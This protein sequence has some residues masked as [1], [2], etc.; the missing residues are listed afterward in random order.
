MGTTKVM[1]LL[2]NDTKKGTEAVEKEKT[3]VEE[4]STEAADEVGEDTV[5]GPVSEETVE[6]EPE[7][8]R[9]K[10]PKGACSICEVVKKRGMVKGICTACRKKA[11]KEKSIEEKEV[12]EEAEEAVEAEEQDE[13]PAEES[14]VEQEV[15]EEEAVAEEVQDEVST[16]EPMD[17]GDSEKED[18]ADTVP[19][20]QESVQEDQVVAL[21]PEAVQEESD[22]V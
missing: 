9:K 6:K 2:E 16:E 5:D 1:K 14:T 13:V 17:V 20:E 15:V 11:E 4:A 21:E 3:A 10:L 19:M 8:R 22:S 12:V 18:T 7:P